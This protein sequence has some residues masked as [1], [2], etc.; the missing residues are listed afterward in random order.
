M[1]NTTYIHTSSVPR[2]RVSD[3]LRSI[4]GQRSGLEMTTY[5]CTCE[6]KEKKCIAEVKTKN[7]RVNRRT[8]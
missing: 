4:Y 5:N 7:I 1:Y 2:T 3:P 6:K 8:V